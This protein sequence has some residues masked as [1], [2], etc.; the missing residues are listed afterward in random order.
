[1]KRESVFG[2]LVVCTSILMG[3]CSSILHPI[4]EDVQSSTIKQEPAWSYEGET[5]PHQW[6]NIDKDFAMCAEGVEQSP[7]N[8]EYTRNIK[9]QVSQSIQIKYSKAK[10][11]V[12]NTGH[13]IQASNL[14]SS[15]YMVIDGEVYKLIQMHFHHPSEHLLNGQ[16]FEMEGHLVHQDD[17]GKYAVLGF[18]IKPGEENGVLDEMWSKLPTEISVTNI[19]LD[20]AVNL[21]QLLPKEKRFFQYR[22]SLTTPPCT[23]GVQWFVLEHPIEMAQQQIEFFSSIFQQNSRPIQKL[24]NRKVF[25]IDE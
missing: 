6:A 20:S 21:G 17:E 15:N 12:E 4:S 7:I 8:I 22:G 10:F 18:F 14:T 11:S 1:M 2:V 24:N 3:G 9:E 5:A 13:T 16:S 19:V 23:E 25:K